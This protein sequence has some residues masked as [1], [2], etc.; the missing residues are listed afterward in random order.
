M[1]AAPK[2]TRAHKDFDNIYNH[3]TFL[4]TGK[5]G[6][7]II[8]TT[9]QHRVAQVTRTFPI[10]ELKPITDE[11][12]WRI[13]AR[14][15]FGNEGYDKY[16]SLEEVGRKIARKCNGLP[17]A[18]KTLGGL[19]RSNDDARKW[20]RI[21]NSNLWAHD[22]V[23][24]ALHIRIDFVVD[25]EGF[26]Q[27]IDGEKAMEVVLATLKIYLDLSYISIESLP[28]ETFM[29]YN[30]Q[31]L[32]SSNCEFLI[33]FPPQIGNLVNLR[34]LDI[35]DTN[36]LEM[37]AQICRLQEL[38]TLTV[39]IVGRQLRIKVIRID[40]LDNLQPSTN[41]KKLNISP[42]QIGQGILHFQTSVLGISGC[43][44]CSS[45]LPFGQL[46]SLMEIVIK[47]MKIVKT[48]GN[49]FYSSNADFPSFQPFPS[50]ES[51]EFEDMSVV[52]QPIL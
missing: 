11:N 52:S 50:L 12:C 13:L 43:N 48:V 8:V 39:F 38:R 28:D 24:P 19:L 2:T 15:A 10:Y 22:D 6:S 23:L 3:E 49:E 30:L 46:P 47:R 40:V 42:F 31:T 5:K 27:Q 4:H 21:L 18:A 34:H 45:L 14:H 44:H 29:L 41:L 16:P 26:L 25:A 33:Q 1:L 9:R 36:L 35:S 20:N 17:L 7:K 51:L 37:P 32:I